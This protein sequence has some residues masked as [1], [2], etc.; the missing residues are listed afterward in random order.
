ML[1]SALSLDVGL[2]TGYAIVRQDML[3]QKL[4]QIE[5]DNGDNLKEMLYSIGMS[6]M[7]SYLLVEYPV[8]NRANPH[9]A[10]LVN[11][12]SDIDEF[13]MNLKGSQSWGLKMIEL[14]PSQ[15][16]IPPILK[17]DLTKMPLNGNFEGKKFS[18]HEK[19]S[20]MICHWFWRWS[21]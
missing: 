21:L 11:L 10:E 6:Y 14:T 9:Y 12:H 4:G 7:P 5:Y 15:W 1:E 8:I 16:K 19:D 18:Q 13:I 3:I 2:T 17:T 20:L